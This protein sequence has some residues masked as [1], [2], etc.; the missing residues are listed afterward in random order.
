ML[1]AWD[2]PDL[3]SSPTTFF[4]L[5]DQIWDSIPEYLEGVKLHPRATIEEIEQRLGRKLTINDFN[6]N[7]H[8]WSTSMLS[9]LRNRMPKQYDILMDRI[10][11]DEGRK[12][13]AGQYLELPLYDENEPHYS[14]EYINAEP[15]EEKKRQHRI[16]NDL[17]MRGSRLQGGIGR[18]MDRSQNY[19]N[20]AQRLLEE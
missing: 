2:R 4:V 12:E 1:K 7:E 15:D 6:N 20:E 5:K 3:P 16:M 10:G 17:K 14:E 19:S 8:N 9:N 18:R 13:L 11:G